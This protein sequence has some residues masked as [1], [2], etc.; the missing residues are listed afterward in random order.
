MTQSSRFSSLEQHNLNR[1]CH[2]IAEWWMAHSVDSLHGG[3]V[4]EIDAK[5]NP[6]ISAN[7]G[8]I[9]NTRILW[10]FSEAAIFHKN[11]EYQKH[12]KRAYE[13]LIEYFDD[14]EHGGVFWE[15]D[16]QG[17]CL[18]VKKQ[19]YAQAFAIYGLSAYYELTGDNTVLDKAL[20]YFDYLERYAS[21]SQEGGYFE[22][23]AQDWQPLQDM[24]LSEKDLNYPKTMNTHLH[25]IEAYTR[26]Y[27]VSNNARV[28]SALTSLLFVF[29]K[30]IILKPSC[31]LSLFQ[32]ADW[33]DCSPA[34]SYGHDI[35]CSWLLWEATQVLKQSDVTE[36]FRPIVIGMAETCLKEAIGERGQFCEQITFSDQKKHQESDWWVQA[37]AIVG[38]LQAYELTENGAFKQAAEKIWQF[39]QEQHI[40]REYGEWFWLALCDQNGKNAI[41][42]AGFWKGPYHN[43]RAMMAASRI[44]EHVNQGVCDEV[45]E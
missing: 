3:F 12:A 33:H 8:I 42:K 30:H 4:G 13:Y 5:S 6:V 39:T 44:L 27:Q 38:F 34:F 40:D 11:A 26:L 24:R 15:L 23:F 2:K 10:F 22:A 41:Y 19:S 14:K 16:Y 17:K 28:G 21:D 35:E 31:H 29:D 1:E 36:H 9:L 20:A 43:G 7:K 37:E 45:A 32:R 18:N 25:I